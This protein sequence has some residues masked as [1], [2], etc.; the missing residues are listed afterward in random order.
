MADAEIVETRRPPGAAAAPEANEALAMR[1][2]FDDCVNYVVTGAPPFE[3]P[4]LRPD[5]AP[6]EAGSF[7][8]VGPADRKPKPE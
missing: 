8:L 6:A 4:D 3:G 7:T 2:I 1:L 5:G